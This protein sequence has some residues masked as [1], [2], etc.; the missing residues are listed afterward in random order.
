MKIWKFAEKKLFGERRSLFEI[1]VY[2]DSSIDLIFATPLSQKPEALLEI[3]I[4]A[5]SCPGDLIID[6]FAGTFT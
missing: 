2:K 3:I 6:L 4:R 1:I 5:I